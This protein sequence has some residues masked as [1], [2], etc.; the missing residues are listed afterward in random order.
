VSVRAFS[1]GDAIVVVGGRFDGYVGVVIGARVG[2]LLVELDGIGGAMWVTGGGGATGGLTSRASSKET[3]K[4]LCRLGSVCEN[5]CAGDESAKGDHDHGDEPREDSGRTRAMIIVYRFGCAAPHDGADVIH[6]QLRLAHRYRNQLVEIEGGRRAAIR[7]AERTYGADIE[8]LL[9]RMEEASTAVD[10]VCQRA[11]AWRSRERTRKLPAD[12]TAELRLAREAE[13]GARAAWREARQRVATEPAVAAWRDVINE[14]ALELVKGARALNGCFWGTGALV[15]LAAAKS[16]ADTPLYGLRGEETDPRFVPFDGSGAVGI[17]LQ[18]TMSVEDALSGSDTRLRI[19][20]PADGWWA[21]RR[22]ERRRM[23]RGAEVALRV[24]SDGR[25]PV[26][27]RWRLDMHRPLPAG[28]RVTWAAVHRTRCG[29]H[30]AWHV[31]ITVDAPEPVASPGRGAVAINLG[32]RVRGDEMR[33]AGWADERDGN[34]ELRLDAATLRVLRLP[35]VMRSERDVALNA[36]RARLLAAA[37]AP[38]N[39]WLAERTKHV[40]AWRSPRRFVALLRDWD[41][42]RP[43]GERQP[44]D[45]DLETYLANDRHAWAQQ[46]HLRQRALRRRREVYR[47]FAARMAAQ[48]DT[49]IAER[50][51]GRERIARTPD[52][53]TPQD[54]KQAALAAN[55]VD[56]AR[57]NRVVACTSEL[58]G[59]LRN[60]GRSRGCAVVALPA[61]DITR[62]CPGCGV[63]DERGAAEHVALACVCGR[64]WDQDTEGAAAELLRRWRERSRAGQKAAPARAAKKSRD[65][66][67]EG[68]S[69]Y[70]RVKRLRAA[71]VLRLETAREVVA[72]CR[73]GLPC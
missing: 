69:R 1:V 33:V 5:G 55:L 6:E 16:F 11:K 31:T 21:A 72:K 45:R 73:K 12:L 52:V 50:A 61:A 10:V 62:I 58:D 34:G 9:R 71:K 4:R 35:E 30:D 51:G 36:A 64:A 54:E 25:A 29:P 38:G 18:G 59:A 44:W 17:Q 68:E 40:H 66:G 56:V 22:C 41:E 53:G 28:A 42:V 26:W 20:P 2:A 32:W 65:S 14:R 46:E 57:A 49:I 24:S 60:A 15:D 43:A 39:A 67:P 70:D 63:P 23:S 48:Y 13:K 37:A 19:T 27:G 8:A 7:S 47:V 3:A